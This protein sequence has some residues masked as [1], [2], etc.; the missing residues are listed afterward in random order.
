MAEGTNGERQ[1]SAESLNNSSD[2]ELQEHGK[3]GALHEEE[4]EKEE[5]NFE[6]LEVNGIDCSENKFFGLKERKK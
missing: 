3:T 4:Y 5:E 6:K 1:N 2:V